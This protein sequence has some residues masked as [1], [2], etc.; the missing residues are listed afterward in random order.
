LENLCNE[1]AIAAARADRS[2]ITIEDFAY[3]MDRQVAGLVS[4]RVVHPDDRRR[5]AYHETGHALLS[6]LNNQVIVEKITIIPHGRALGYALPVPKDERYIAT[7]DDLWHRLLGMLGGRAAELVFFGSASTGASDDF[8]KAAQLVK[9]MIHRYNLTS[10]GLAMIPDLDWKA[11][12]EPISRIVD[13][14]MAVACEWVARYRSEVT[15]VAERLLVQETILWEEMQACWQAIP[16]GS[17][18]PFPDPN[19]WTFYQV[20]P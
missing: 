7:A 13:Q 3:A 14:G 19:A 8:E 10:W 20:A 1:A 15:Q 2:S 9:D 4:H 17:L 11:V 12:Q 16:Q 6:W 18:P 5:V